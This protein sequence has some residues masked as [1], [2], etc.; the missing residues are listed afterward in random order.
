MQAQESDTTQVWEY[1]KDE[2]VQWRCAM[3]NY[4]NAKVPCHGPVVAHFVANGGG[5][6]RKPAGQMLRGQ[7]FGKAQS[8]WVTAKTN[9]PQNV[10]HAKN[11]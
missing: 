10:I 4:D 6:S 5:P 11:L 2:Q 3:L 9:A 8:Q 7:H 1:I